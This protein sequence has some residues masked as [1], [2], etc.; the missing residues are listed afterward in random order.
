MHVPALI[1]LWLFG[2]VVAWPWKSLMNVSLSLQT[3]VNWP[4]E[5]ETHAKTYWKLD[6]C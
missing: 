2:G 1:V 6:T 5:K 4:E 3:R